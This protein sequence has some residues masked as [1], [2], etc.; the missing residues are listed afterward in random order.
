MKKHIVKTQHMVNREGLKLHKTKHKKGRKHDYDVY[1]NNHPNT[2]I[3]V[4]DVFDLGY[5]GVQND[6]PTV[7]SVCTAI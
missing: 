6:F 3:Q 2:P 5:M 4:E 7:K 1:K